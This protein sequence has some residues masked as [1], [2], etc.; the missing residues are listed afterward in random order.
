ML[1]RIIQSPKEGEEVQFLGVHA[2]KWEKVVGG[3]LFYP[4][5]AFVEATEE[6]IGKEYERVFGNPP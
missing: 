4:S 2:V 3:E 6:E 5:V 1:Y